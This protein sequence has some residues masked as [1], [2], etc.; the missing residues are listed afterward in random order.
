MPYIECPQKLYSTLS[1]K[2]VIKLSGDDQHVNNFPALLW[3]VSRSSARKSA[4][5]LNYGQSS[6]TSLNCRRP[7]KRTVCSVMTMI[8]LRNCMSSNCRWKKH[9][10]HYARVVWQ[11]TIDPNS[12]VMVKSSMPPTSAQ[13]CLQFCQISCS[14]MRYSQFVTRSQPTPTVWFSRMPTARMMMDE[15]PMPRWLCQNV[16]KPA[17]YRVAGF[18]VPR[19]QKD[20]AESHRLSFRS[21]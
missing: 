17:S 13:G 20:A 7:L 2:Q 4:M 6:R 21:S 8:Y 19:F 9:V 10:F 16:H 18:F 12:Q 5:N 1:P 3:V 15:S 14:K 11:K